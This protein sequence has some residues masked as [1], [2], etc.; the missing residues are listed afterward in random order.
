MDYADFSEQVREFT[1]SL[2]VLL[3][4]GHGAV[5]SAGESITEALKSHSHAASG[6]KRTSHAATWKKRSC[7]ALTAR[8]GRGLRPRVYLG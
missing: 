5:M 4:A 6:K 1:Q 3:F 2:S 7:G 8:R